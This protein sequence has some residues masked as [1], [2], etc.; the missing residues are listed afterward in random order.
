MNRDPV[1]ISAL[2]GVGVFCPPTPCRWVY[3]GRGEAAGCGGTGGSCGPGVAPSGLELRGCWALAVLGRVGGAGCRSMFYL[4]RLPP[5]PP[6]PV[7]LS[8]P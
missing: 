2:F 1:F 8:S 4:H 5:Q 3:G 7:M 6:F